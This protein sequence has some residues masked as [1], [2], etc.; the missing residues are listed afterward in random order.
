MGKMR[1]IGRHATDRAA[2]GPRLTEFRSV[3]SCPMAACAAE[4]QALSGATK[5]VAA[6]RGAHDRPPV[7]VWRLGSGCG[8]RAP[9]LLSTPMLE[10]WR[11]NLWR[12][13][14]WGR[15]SPPG[16]PPPPCGRAGTATFSGGAGAGVEAKVPS[17][18]PVEAAPSR[19]ARAR[20][21]RRGVEGCRV[22]AGRSRRWPPAGGIEAPSRARA[23]RLMLPGRSC[24]APGAVEALARG[25]GRQGALPVPAGTLERAPGGRG[26]CAVP[27]G[28]SRVHAP[29]EQGWRPRSCASGL[30]ARTYFSDSMKGDPPPD[31]RAQSGPRSSER[32]GR[33]CSR[34]LTDR[35]LTPWTV[36]ERWAEPSCAVPGRAAKSLFG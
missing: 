24:H 2:G 26:S 22:E 34:A 35:A 30:L 10:F 32:C 21:S 25:R 4:Y 6:V 9:N 18:R 5:G 23:E 1:G 19:R 15:R 7:R 28:W 3:G 14:T 36:G 27:E 17:G 8:F 29:G 31:G 33:R 20:P 16:H 12:P 11:W 13:Q